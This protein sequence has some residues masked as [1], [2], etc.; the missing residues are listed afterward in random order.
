MATPATQQVYDDFYSG[1]TPLANAVVS[2]ILNADL[3]TSISTGVAIVPTLQSTTTDANGHWFLNLVPTTDLSP[4][5]LTYCVT[6]P[7]RTYNI[8]VGAAGPY[9]S[10]AA[11]TIVAR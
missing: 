10:T 4:T 1:A 8:I 2:A 5:G 9:R 11:G 6:T 3:A 7:F